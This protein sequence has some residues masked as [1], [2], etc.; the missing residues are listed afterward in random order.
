VQRKGGE[1]IVYSAFQIVEGPY[2][3]ATLINAMIDEALAASAVCAEFLRTL[4]LR[5]RATAP[6]TLVRL[7]PC[8][9]VARN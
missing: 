2:P 7:P 6:H 1:W 3:S 8:E 4:S 9:S 5:L